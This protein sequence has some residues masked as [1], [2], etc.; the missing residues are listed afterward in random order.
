MKSSTRVT[1][2][3]SVSCFNTTFLTVGVIYESNG[4]NKIPLNMREVLK[5]LLYTHLVA[6]TH[7]YSAFDF[8]LPHLKVD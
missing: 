7:S 8:I 2:I 1:E 4:I 3:K 5:N 6:K